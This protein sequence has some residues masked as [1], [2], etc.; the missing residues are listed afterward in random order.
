[1]TFNIE[2][3]DVASRSA[4]WPAISGLVPIR[5]RLRARPSIRIFLNA[6]RPLD[7]RVC[8]LSFVPTRGTWT[9]YARAAEVN[10]SVLLSDRRPLVQ[11]S[12]SQASLGNHSR[13]IAL[14]STCRKTPIPLI[15]PRLQYP[16][17]GASL[18]RRSVRTELCRARSEAIRP[19]RRVP[20]NNEASSTFSG[21]TRQP[22]L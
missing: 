4:G 13:K 21:R 20:L 11:W 6:E 9:Y 17:R 5:Y 14:T 2:V 12:P 16:S 15:L 1:M 18:R 10:K 19:V 22:H 3:Y 8:G 7:A